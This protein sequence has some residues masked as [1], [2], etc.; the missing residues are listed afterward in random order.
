MLTFLSI[1]LKEKGKKGWRGAPFGAPWVPRFAGAGPSAPPR[2]WL[3][4]LGILWPFF[5]RFR[6]SPP[7]RFE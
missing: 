7:F 5:I 6:F 1:I 3:V 4:E 2:F